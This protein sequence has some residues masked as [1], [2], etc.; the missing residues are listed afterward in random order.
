[1]QNYDILLYISIRKRT[2]TLVFAK[3]KAKKIATSL[4][5]AKNGSYRK[6]E[7]EKSTENPQGDKSGVLY[8]ACIAT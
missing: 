6:A 2:N 8:Y 7:S 1:M 4:L 5:L 3:N